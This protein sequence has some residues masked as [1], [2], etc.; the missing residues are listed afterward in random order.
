MITIQL[1]IRGATE[2]VE[3][4]DGTQAGHIRT[5]SDKLENMGAPSAFAIAVDGQQVS[6]T[7]I[8]PD[9]A[10]VTLRPL[11]GEKGC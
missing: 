3:L 11:T 10:Q 2:S 5:L 9:N 4:Q 7:E 1:T 6:D 8:L